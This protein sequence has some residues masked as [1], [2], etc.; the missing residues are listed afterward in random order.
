MVKLLLEKLSEN[1]TKIIAKKQNTVTK[2]PHPGIGKNGP[3]ISLIKCKAMY[4]N[5]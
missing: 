5:L 4:Y 3:A 2:L 1:R